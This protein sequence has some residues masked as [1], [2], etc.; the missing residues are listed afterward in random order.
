MSSSSS[1]ESSSLGSW[2][3]FMV[4]VGSDFHFFSSLKSGKRGGVSLEG[5]VPC[6]VVVVVG[7]CCGLSSH[8]IMSALLTWCLA[9]TCSSSSGGCTSQSISF[10]CCTSGFQS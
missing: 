1:E 3:C 6:A 7:G 9:K 4:Y 2:I 5:D 8:L 10:L